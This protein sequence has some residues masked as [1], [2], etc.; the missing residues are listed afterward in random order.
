MRTSILVRHSLYKL[1]SFSVL[2]VY[3]LV[4]VFRALCWLRSL[5]VLVPVLVNQ[6]FILPIIIRRLQ[7][8]DLTNFQI[9]SGANTTI[10]IID[11]VTVNIDE[12]VAVDKRCMLSDTWRP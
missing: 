4:F 10:D 6:R 8:P 9:H 11:T 5:L 7:I 12:A 3:A 1:P 2:V